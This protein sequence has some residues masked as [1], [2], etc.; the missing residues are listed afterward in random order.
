M[1][2]RGR[3]L[4]SP[5]N[6]ARFCAPLVSCAAVRGKAHLPT[7]V[8]RRSIPP[9]R[10]PPPLRS[11]I[12]QDRYAVHHALPSSLPDRQQTAS[13][14]SCALHACQV[15]L[16]GRYAS[17]CTPV[18]CAGALHDRAANSI[19]FHPNPLGPE[20]RIRQ[21][22]RLCCTRRRSSSSTRYDL[23]IRHVRCRGRSR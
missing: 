6:L 7:G 18:L 13:A 3:F 4:F 22:I 19:E 14:C 5:C 9:L 23:F 11:F 16:S 12:R 2:V 15:C 17:V 1:P 20:P 21:C 8:V 10:C